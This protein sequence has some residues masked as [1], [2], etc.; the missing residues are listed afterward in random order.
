MTPTLSDILIE[1]VGPL[2]SGYSDPNGKTWMSMCEE[3]F[4]AALKKEYERGV[5]DG[6][7]EVIQTLVERDLLLGET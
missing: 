3:R 5:A 4:Q 1:P 6:Q 2:D 7:T